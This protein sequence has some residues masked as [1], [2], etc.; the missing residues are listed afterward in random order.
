MHPNE[1]LKPR[2]YSSLSK[3]QPDPKEKI[4]KQTNRLHDHD[5]ERND[6]LNQKQKV[7]FASGDCENL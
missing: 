1:T 4:R 7:P 6:R 2:D 3:R 5:H